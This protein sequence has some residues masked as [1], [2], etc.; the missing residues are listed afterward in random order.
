MST[1]KRAIGLPAAT[2]LVVGTI[3]GASIFRQ[4][5]DIA[6]LVPDPSAIVGAWAVAGLLTLIGALVC[7]ELA[8]AYP[9][10]GGVYVFLNLIYTPAVGF[11]WGWATFWTMHTG[12]LAAIAMVFASYAAFFVPLDLNGQRAV[13]IT[14]ILVLS[15][16]NYIGAKFGG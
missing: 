7:A 12:I 4:A 16:L 10:T 11:L 9:K 5:S 3:V 15:A 6:Q 2:A 14:A 8:S 13:A 1:L